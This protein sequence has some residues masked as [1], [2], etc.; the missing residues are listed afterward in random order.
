VLVLIRFLP[1]IFF[2]NDLV[3]C[4]YSHT[5]TILSFNIG[6]RSQTTR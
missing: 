4:I 2:L 1:T 6:K 3:T 5:M